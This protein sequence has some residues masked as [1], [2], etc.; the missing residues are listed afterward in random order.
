VS[1]ALDFFISYTPA[2][3]KWAVWIAATLENEGF[4]TMLQAWDFKLGGNFI[5]D[6]DRG[7]TESTLVIAVLSPRYLQSRYGRME[8]QAALRSSPED[9]QRR[10]LPILVEDCELEGLLAPITYVDLAHVFDRR[11]AEEILLQRVRQSLSGRSTPDTPP[12]FPR[13]STSGRRPRRSPM[14]MPP[15]P[16]E[17]SPRVVGPVSVLHVAGPSFGQGVPATPA[18]IVG[19]VR[20]MEDA[21]APSPGLLIIPGG[22]T[23]DAA[24]PD[25]QRAAEFIHTLRTELDLR[26]ER[27]VIVPGRGDVSMNQSNAYFIECAD[28]GVAPMRPYHRKWKHF[29]ALLNELYG[30]INGIDFGAGAPWTKFTVPDLRI[31]VAGFNTTYA[32]SHLA[33]DDRGLIGEEQTNAFRGWLR[34]QERLGWLRIGVM[35]HAPVVD[36]LD[37]AEDFHTDIA[38]HLNLLFHGGCVEAQSDRVPTLSMP[39]DCKAEIVAIDAD[40][41]TR[42]GCS[43]APLRVQCGW[44]DAD[45]TFGDERDQWL[46]DDPRITTDPT[47]GLLN[48]LREACEVRYSSPRIRVI[49]QSPPYLN[50]TY[51]VDRVIVQTCLIPQAG[52]PTLKDVDHALRVAAEQEGQV[53]L[54]YTGDRPPD[55]VFARALTGR[56]E[57]RSL[58]EFQGLLDLRHYVAKQTAD[59]NQSQVYPPG[60]YVPQRFSVVGQTDHPGGDDL[61]GGLLETLKSDSGQFVL[62]LADF[63]GGKTFS[64]RE[65]ARRAATALPDQIPM[66]IEMRRLE[67]DHTIDELIASHLA[68]RGERKVD[69]AAFDYM[70]REGRIL[71]LFDGFDEL[72]SRTTY[73]RAADRLD[74]V[75]NA[76]VGKAKVVLTSRSQHFQ[77]REQVFTALGERV[78][79]LPQQRVL[80][81]HQFTDEDV[82]TYLLNHFDQNAGLADERL[83]LIRGVENLATLAKNPRMLSFVVRLEPEQLREV[84]NEGRALSAAALY[85]QILTTWL[86]FEKER[87][88]STATATPGLTIDQM[89]ATVTRLATRLWESG[90]ELLSVSA[91]AEIAATLDTIAGSALSTDEAAQAIGSRSLL[92]RTDADLF[93]FIH[94]SVKEWLI[95]REIARQLDSGEQSPVLLAQRPLTQLTIDFLCDLAQSDRCRAWASRNVRGA[96]AAQDN[97]KRMLGRLSAPSTRMLERTDLSGVD[98]SHRD[99][100]EIKLAGARITDAM[101]NHSNLAGADLSGASLDGTRLDHAR[102]NGADLRRASMRRTRLIGADL[103]DVAIEHSDWYR[104]A[105]VAAVGVEPLRTMPELRQAAVVPRDPIDVQLPPS[106]VSV[107]Y[108]FHIKSGRLPQNLAYSEA[109]DLLAIGC[110][111]G[112]VLVYDVVVGRII[113]TLTGHRDR[114]YG[115]AAMSDARFASISADRTVRC[116]N[117]LTGA[118]IWQFG[119]LTGTGWPLAVDHRSNTVAVSDQTGAMF[120]L[121]ADTGALVRTIRNLPGTVWTAVFSPDDRLLAIGGSDAKVRVFKVATGELLWERSADRNVYRV[122]ISANGALLAASDDAGVIQVWRTS[123]GQAVSTLSG[124][125]QAVY[126]LDLHPNG[127]LLVSGDTSGLIKLWDVRDGRLLETQEHHRGPVY[128]VR[129]SR[130][131]TLMVSS[132]SDGNCQIWSLDAADPT[133][134]LRTAVSLVGHMSSVWPPIF[135]NDDLEIATASNDESVR[136]WDVGTGQCKADI[137]GHGRQISTLSFNKSS[138]MLAA[139]SKDGLVRIW[140]PLTGEQLQ[141]LS[142]R[143]N[144]LVSA[145]F[146]PVADTVVAATNDGGAHRFNAATGMP[147]RELRLKTVNV[148]A[149][150]FSPNGEVIATANDD[151]SVSLWNHRTGAQGHNLQLHKGRVRSISFTS[152]GDLLATGCDDGKVRVWAVD[153]GICTET[154]E[155]HTNRVYG[156]QFNHDATLLASGGWD[157]TVRIWARDG[158]RPVKTLADNG[159]R[160]WAIAYH[161]ALD[162]LACAGDDGRIHLWDAR[163]GRKLVALD[164]HMGKIVAITFSPD[165][166]LLATGGDD[167]AVRIWDVTDLSAPTLKVT[168]IGQ[169]E[170]WAAVSPQGRYKVHDVQGAFWYAVGGCRFDVGE[171]D[172][173]VPEIA[174]MFMSQEF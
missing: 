148:W 140:S 105:V 63:G 18:Q 116:W 3:E 122:V 32:M 165:G 171:L 4:R 47:T 33:A 151:D 143:A 152:A 107:P 53:E 101:L 126:T 62:L 37:D 90:E 81:I 1:R 127:W 173:V 98:W 70:L 174:R 30:G 113:R 94:G 133:P 84:A 131:G 73:A 137:R 159:G 146:S 91:I 145:V 135:R 57:L 22:L 172:P 49:D 24:R 2:D 153:E 61:V 60:L 72:L 67:K 68:E 158:W 14:T 39:E 125:P 129:F 120:L 13:T 112:G 154:L 106:V 55:G 134:A 58:I 119:D 48:H 130:K 19:Q 77:S 34:D 85:N 79:R 23:A 160:L 45:A 26:P 102:L 12:D 161:P 167:G 168:L 139:A 41:Y 71:L 46:A 108:G 89:W 128:Q 59:L 82:R 66:L 6:M 170:G 76:A 104:A 147:E 28:D 36:Q 144:Q 80:N 11:H 86:R 16:L 114:A 83:R 42:W 40:G 9:P 141:R 17:R 25:F 78:G 50:V 35:S 157:G 64:M 123:D 29:E 87:Q 56:V 138:S 31:A 99:L 8:W 43:P 44:P 38:G 65:L 163:A 109:G 5:D 20:R 75:L 124:H 52:T 117:A 96:A 69:L 164:A 121:D 74:M 149:E 142:G 100:P 15:F 155:G 115:V 166:R 156:V 118:E 110:D 10:L 54:V 88:P 111:N 136:L 93:G 7:L 97:A 92:V 103:T 169:A 51:A 162:V 21:G 150:A 95:A 27:I 132:D